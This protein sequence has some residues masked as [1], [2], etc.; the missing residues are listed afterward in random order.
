[1]VNHAPVTLD[2]SPLTMTKFLRFWFPL[3]CYSAI[4]SFVSSLSTVPVPYTEISFDKLLHA[5]EYGV[6]GFLLARALG[7]CERKFS[8][9]VIFGVVI[10]ISLVYGLLD[11]YHQSFVPGRTCD[12]IDVAADWLGGVL[13]GWVYIRLVQKGKAF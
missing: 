2:K 9:H 6:F 5:G 4:I 7:S 12:L 3:L 10:I 1:V 11:E 8:L 13:G